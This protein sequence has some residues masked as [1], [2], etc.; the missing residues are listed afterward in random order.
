MPEISTKPYLIRAIYEWCSDNGYKPY[1]AVAVDERT[2]VPREFVK[3]GEIVLNL[4]A[5]A[6]NHLRIGNELIE[7]QARFNRVA[8]E[9]SIPIENVIAIYASESGHG[10]AFEAPHASQPAAGGRV[11]RSTDA[12]AGNSASR[13]ADGARDPERTGEARDRDADGSGTVVE[14]K[15]S[16]G[17]GGR[18][19][20][21]RVGPSDGDGDPVSPDAASAAD[22][23]ATEARNGPLTLVSN[24]PEQPDMVAGSEAPATSGSPEEGP[25]GPEGPDGPAGS[26]RPRLT[27]IK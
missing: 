4:S 24:E 18:G 13:S 10:M 22:P 19:R 8:R 15:R 5:S 6:T 14:L 2:V 26:P 1:I 7:F 23:P 9:L 16:P 12:A 17:K 27:R 11:D 21:R 25:E 3:N 20:P